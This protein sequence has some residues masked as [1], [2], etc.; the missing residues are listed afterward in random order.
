[1]ATALYTAGHSTRS[2]DEFREL[3]QGHGVR[4][5]VDVRR[6]PGSR[7][8]PHFNADALERDLATA[9]IRYRHEEALGG[10]RSGRANS[11][12]DA[13]RNAGFRA[14]AD[15]A[16]TAEFR[17]ALDRV[18]RDAARHRT[19]VMCAEAVPWRCHRRILADHAV[20]RGHRV[21]HILSPDRI[22]EHELEPHARVAE[23]GTVR[24]PARG[25]DQLDML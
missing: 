8:H 12:N 2:S 3:L 7:R 22:T 10:R 20:A 1:M 6:F 11:P 5:L 23:D 14:Y 25:D 9:G 13:W 16:L 18:L 17:R 24:Y 19:A 15:H 4:L 21:L